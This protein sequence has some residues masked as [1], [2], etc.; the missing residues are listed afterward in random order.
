[1]QQNWPETSPLY[2]FTALMID[3]KLTKGIAEEKYYSA[4]LYDTEI[5][6]TDSMEQRPF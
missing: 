3:D 1:M 5:Y 4:C 2:K 6:P